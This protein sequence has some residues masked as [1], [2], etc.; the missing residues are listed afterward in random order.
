ML[1]LIDRKEAT[2]R[3]EEM[4]ISLCLTWKGCRCPC[5]EV[6]EEA[7]GEVFHSLRLQGEGT[8]ERGRVLWEEMNEQRRCRGSGI[9]GDGKM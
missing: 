9:H 6:K 8:W 3:L 4:H 2:L 7:L 1:G 5:K